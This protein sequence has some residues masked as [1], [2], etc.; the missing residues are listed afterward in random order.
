M[1]P[2]QLVNSNHCFEDACYLF[3]QGLIGSVI[4]FLS[5]EYGG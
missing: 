2:C 3:L 4:E 5:P 1:T